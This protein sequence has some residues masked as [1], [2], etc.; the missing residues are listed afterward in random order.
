MARIIIEGSST[1]Y[2]LWAEGQG[3]WAD[4]IKGTYM[5]TPGSDRFAGVINL[6]TPNKTVAESVV[7]LEAIASIQPRRSSVHVGLY[8]LGMVESRF[9]DGDRE[10]PLGQFE[11]LVRQLGDASLRYGYQPIFIGM[12]PIDEDRTRAVPFHDQIMSY[13]E[14]ER[15][16]YDQA[17]R[18]YA[19]ENGYAY[20]D[21]EEFFKTT[22]PDTE[23]ILAS[24]GL[25]VNAIGHAA[26]HDFILPHIDAEFAR[27]KATK[28]HRA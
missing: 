3:G 6:A 28:K 11:R 24:D 21:V 16:A 9:V 2:G 26:L 18:A 14:E 25:H 8:Q 20:L 10:M 12:P 13:R 15:T 7:S 23:N 17:V 4:R 19:G 1:A 27:Q 5:D 22:H